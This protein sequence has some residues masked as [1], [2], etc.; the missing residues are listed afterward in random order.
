MK[1]VL[2]PVIL[3]VLG[4]ESA[5]ATMM[6]KKSTKA[7]IPAYIRV[8]DGGGQFHCEAADQQCSDVAEG[9]FCIWEQDN[10]TELYNID[11]GTMCGSKLYELPN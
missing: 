3:V 8:S 5:F 7:V 9:P 6:V 2:F 1:K 11:T 4:T 10:S